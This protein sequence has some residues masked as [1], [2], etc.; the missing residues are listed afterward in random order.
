MHDY[1]DARFLERLRNL[2]ILARRVA[3]G[4]RRAEQRSLDLGSGIEFHDHRQYSPRDEFRAIDWNVYR[5]LGK[6]FVRLFEEQE[7]LPLYLLPDVSASMFVED[8]PRARAGLRCALALAAISMNQHDRVAV[9]PC[10]DGL[11]APLRP[12]TGKNR[13]LDVASF[14]AR[15]EPGGETDLRKALRAFSCLGLRPGL[16]ALISDFFDPA[17]GEALAAAL[18]RLRHRLL[19]VQL[20]R[21]SDE[22]PPFSGEVRFVDAESGDARDVT[23]DRAALLRYGAAYAAFQRALTACARSRGAPLL[24]LDVEQDEV[25]QLAALFESRKYLA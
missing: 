18:G 14:L 11:L 8:V 7:D 13:L 21:A 15:L 17:G 6:V 16:V 4:G 20:V 3:R 9:F 12:V 24:R 1:F 5:R 25:A 23:V 2:R 19:L 10:A 22:S